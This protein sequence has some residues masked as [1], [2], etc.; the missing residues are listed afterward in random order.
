MNYLIAFLSGTAVMMLE[1]AGI[2]LLNNIFINNST[3]IN[4]S[5]IGIVMLA[6]SLGYYIGGKLSSDNIFKEKLYIFFLITLIHILLFTNCNFTLLKYCAT[7]NFAPTIQILFASILL[8]LIPSI[9]LGMVTPYVIQIISNIPKNSNMAGAISGKVYAISTLGS[10]TGTFLCGYYFIEKY[11]LSFSFYFLSILVLLCLIFSYI[12]TSYF[13]EQKTIIKNF[14]KWKKVLIASI[15][16]IALIGFI[17]SVTYKVTSERIRTEKI[18]NSMC[19]PYTDNY[20]I[21]TFSEYLKKHN[22]PQKVDNLKKGLDEI[23]IGY[24]DKYLENSKY[25][26]ACINK[27]EKDN[28]WSNYDK[29]LFADFEKQSVPNLYKELGYNPYIWK[30]IYGMKDLP[31]EILRNINGK[32][33]IDIGAYP[34]DTI[35]TFHKNFPKSKIF[36]Y[37]PVSEQV[38][39]MYKNIDK[40]KLEDPTFKTVEVI[41]K[42]LGDKTETTSISFHYSD[43]NAQMAKLDDEYKNLKRNNLGLIKIDVEGYESAVI[44]GAETVIKKYKPTIVIAIYH[45]PEDFFEMKDKLKKLNPN[46]KFIIR[47][48]EDI[49]ADADLVLI[50]Y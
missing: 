24:I 1:I 28:L 23:S 40:M 17:S 16:I 8:Y 32:D 37:E 2:E 42:G 27:N 20:W 34:A 19:T 44:R 43:N 35:Y 29:K 33:I 41:K 45:T 13:S 12:E 14:P 47:R 6:L 46:Y 31:E 18:K 25:W 48:S 26:F 5:V 21:S 3:Q 15:G 38:N 9:C 50:A 10:I 36:A 11:K 7:L 39:I 4:T 30:S 49:I 22:M